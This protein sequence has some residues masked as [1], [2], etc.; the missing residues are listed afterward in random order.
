MASASS[1][2]AGA[3]AATSLKAAE[4]ATSQEQAMWTMR[5]TDNF[6]MIQY[7]PTNTMAGG[8]LDK[9]CEVNCEQQDAVVSLVWRTAVR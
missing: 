4:G 1:L 7:A 8:G 3:A 6:I 2:A 9:K 5:V